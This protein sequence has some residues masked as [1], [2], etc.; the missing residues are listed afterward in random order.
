MKAAVISGIIFL[1]LVVIA[2]YMLV[3]YFNKKRTQ[4]QYDGEESGIP[5]EK[6]ATPPL[7]SR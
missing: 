6:L 7:S 1:V 4:I 5:S 2:L 3:R